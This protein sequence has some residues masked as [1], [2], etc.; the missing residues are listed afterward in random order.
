MTTAH[1]QKRSRT[2]MCAIKIHDKLFFRNRQPQMQKWH[3][4]MTK[5]GIFLHK[6]SQLAV[7]KQPISPLKHTEMRC[8]TH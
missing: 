6:K 8:E 4:E 2:G 1:A 5:Q 7:I 3:M